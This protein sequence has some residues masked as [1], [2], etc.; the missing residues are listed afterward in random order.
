MTQAW[1]QL[2]KSSL[3][4]P[5]EQQALLGLLKEQGSN[6]QFFEQFRAVIIAVTKREANKTRLALEKFR[7][8]VVL[9]EKELFEKKDKLWQTVQEKLAQIAID[10]IQKREEILQDYHQ[11]VAILW[12][13]LEEKSHKMAAAILSEQIKSGQKRNEHN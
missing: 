11:Q 13:E 5:T 6:E 10:D 2:I 1:I 9:A 3:L 8:Q 12:Q 4:T 7:E